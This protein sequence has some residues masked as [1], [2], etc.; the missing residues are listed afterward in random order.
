MGVCQ[1]AGRIAFLH[2]NE[3]G[4]IG[5][6]TSVLGDAGINIDNMSNKSKGD[7]AYTMMDIDVSIADDVLAKM[8]ALPGVIKARVIK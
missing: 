7:F 2:K 4:A 5:Q 8:Q 1:T 6:F 3:K